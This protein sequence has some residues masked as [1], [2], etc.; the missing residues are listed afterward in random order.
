MPGKRQSQVPPVSFHME[1]CLMMMKFNQILTPLTTQSYLPVAPLLITVGLQESP[2]VFGQMIAT[3]TCGI[4]IAFLG[5][6]P[7]L[8]VL[9]TKQVLLSSYSLRILAGFLWMVPLCF[10]VGDA[11]TMPLLFV[12]RFL[13]GLSLISFALPMA[14]IGV[15]MQV[16]DR[17]RNVAIM[18]GLI[19]LGII[20]GPPVGILIADLAPKGAPLNLQLQGLDTFAYASVGLFT[21]FVA[22]FLLI[23]CFLFFD[24]DKL[25]TVDNPNEE[26]R[27]LSR[28]TKLI[29]VF[30][31]IS[32]FAFHLAFL[33]GFESTM[34][35]QM[36]AAYEW[37]FHNSLQAW[38]PFALF[39]FVF[40]IIIIPAA[41]E[42]LNS[43]TAATYGVVF[44][45][46]ST[47]GINWFDFRM[48]VAPWLFVAENMFAN[49]FGLYGQVLNTRMSTS[50]PARLQVRMQSIVALVSQLGRAVGPVLATFVFD[51]SQRQIGGPGAGTNMSRVYMLLVGMPP[52]IVAL[53]CF[54]T[55]VFGTYFDL[56]PQQ[57][58]RAKQTTVKTML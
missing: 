33:A 35:L 46:M 38:I 20:L 31:I 44:A 52:C 4:V 56:S 48:P 15:R 18:G 45:A 14:W 51:I 47:A 21:I 8:S 53:S 49:G 13:F 43:A 5:M 50:L 23:L 39:S 57:L 2:Q 3:T 37:G 29:V 42:N 24:D 30:N 19:R 36:Y 26:H 58:K 7:L 10:N 25:L 54:L 9:S 55:P 22:F 16:E 32:V 11:A 34:T 40:S 41:I 6:I 12:S 28:E 27:P 17:P 1:K